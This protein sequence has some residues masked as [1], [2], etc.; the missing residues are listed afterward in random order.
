M[1]E[2]SVFKPDMARLGPDRLGL[3]SFGLLSRLF[4]EEVARRAETETG[5]Y[6]PLSLELLREAA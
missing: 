4:T 3:T 2:L 5:A 6:Q 1:K